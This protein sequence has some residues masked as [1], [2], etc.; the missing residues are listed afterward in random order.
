MEIDT[1]SKSVLIG[2]A[3]AVVGILVLILAFLMGWGEI[4][5]VLGV[6]LAVVGVVIFYLKPLDGAAGTAKPKVAPASKAKPANSAKTAKN[7]G[8]SQLGKALTFAEQKL[9]EK[10]DKLPSSVVEFYRGK[11]AAY[12]ELVGKDEESALIGMSQVIGA[13]VSA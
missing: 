5:M 6:L 7:Y 3:V 11:I 4:V 10:E 8:D 13:I 9:N 12:A 1:S 2:S